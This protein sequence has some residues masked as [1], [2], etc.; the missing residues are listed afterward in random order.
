[1]TD[2][3]VIILARLEKLRFL[4]AKHSLTA[5]VLRKNPNL[6]W[7]TGGRVHVPMTIDLACFDLIVNVNSV[8]A[9]VNAIEAPRLAAEEFPSLIELKVIDWWEG[10]DSYL[11]SGFGIGSDQ[12]GRGWLDLTEEIEI[13][14]SSLIED[15]LTRLTSVSIDAAKALGAAMKEVNSDD[16]EIDVAAHITSALWKSNLEAVFLGV[17]G[18]TRCRDIRHPLPTEAI[19]GSRGIASICARRKG[20]IASATRI[21]TFGEVSPEHFGQYERLLRVE[22]EMLNATKIGEP[23]ASVIAVTTHA[24]ERYGFDPHEWQRHHQGGPTGY[25][26]R[27][28]AASLNSI[29]P[30]ASNQPISW[31]PTALG[32]KVEDTWITSHEG[33]ELLTLDANWP[34]I[35]SGKRM[36]PGLLQRPK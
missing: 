15:D 16:R 7:I 1:M 27:D 21:V 31:N 29:R 34:M 32:W 25:L 8:T 24:Y 3:N 19:I 20:L 14:R 5:I 4:L 9:V 22:E 28:W 11:P 10:R 17:A 33:P 13:L 36:R 12:A 18:E 35:A 2:D 6:A 30:I 26:P 23:F